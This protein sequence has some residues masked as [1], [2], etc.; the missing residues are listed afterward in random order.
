M[1]RTRHAFAVSVLALL[2]FAVGTRPLCAGPFGEL[3][4]YLPDDSN[5]IVVVNAAAIYDSALG[6]KEG[7]RQKYADRFEAAPLI[8]PPSANRCVIGADLDLQSM[9]TKWEAA[10]M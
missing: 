1:T 10:A 6:Q 8:L 9:H 2:V 5:A 4:K 3:A 7:L